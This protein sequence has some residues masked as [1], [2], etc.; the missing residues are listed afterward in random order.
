MAKQMLPLDILR[1]IFSY[2]NVFIIYDKETG[3][4]II[5]RKLQKTDIRY[6]FLKTIP[7]K[8]IFEG[9]N[10]F[11]DLFVGEK[12]YFCLEYFEPDSTYYLETFVIET[13]TNDNEYTTP[14]ENHKCKLL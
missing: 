8:R 12:K 14:V 10:T 11:V 4:Y 7:K 9:W 1:H 2:D 3:K 5:H 13:L 6:I